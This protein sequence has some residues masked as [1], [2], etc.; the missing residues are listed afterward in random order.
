MKKISVFFV[1]FLFSVI[2]IVLSYRFFG[3]NL[4]SAVLPCAMRAVIFG[5]LSNIWVWARN[6]NNFI[7]FGI[8]SGG[9]TVALPVIVVSYGFALPVVIPFLLLWTGLVLFGIWL[10]KRTP[11]QNR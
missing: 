2:S 4:Y 11:L 3:D 6:N 10:N 9:F 1:G 7:L 8:F 5:Y